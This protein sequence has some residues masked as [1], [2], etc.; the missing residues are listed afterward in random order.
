MDSSKRYPVVL[1]NLKQGKLVDYN[2]VRVSD[3]LQHEENWTVTVIFTFAFDKS[4]SPLTPRPE[5]YTGTG[6]SK[7]EALSF[8]SFS[9]LQHLGY[10]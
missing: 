6:H 5:G 3:G 8:A 10:I 7:G 9:A 2:V 1:N 4:G